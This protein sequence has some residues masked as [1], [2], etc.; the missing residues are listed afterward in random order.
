MFPLKLFDVR[1]QCPEV[2]RND[3]VC[4]YWGL[5]RAWLLGQSIF[6][7]RSALVTPL[8]YRVQD[9]DTLRAWV[10]LEWIFKA[11]QLAGA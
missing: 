1:P 4:F 5:A 9:I 2:A 10:P 11:Q 7:A 8:R 3:A 6:S